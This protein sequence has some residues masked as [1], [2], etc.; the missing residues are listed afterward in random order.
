MRPQTCPHR[1]RTNV[2]SVF[3]SLAAAAAVFFYL[4]VTFCALFAAFFLHFCIFSSGGVVHWFIVSAGSVH[5]FSSAPHAAQKPVR[6][7]EPPPGR[8]MIIMRATFCLFA[9]SPPPLTHN[10]F[11]AGRHC[12][13][14]SLLSKGNGMYNEPRDN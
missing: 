14:L 9:F 6:Y 13:S 3:S 8:G 1:P 10:L 5:L 12:D 2:Q 11:L 7:K 4:S